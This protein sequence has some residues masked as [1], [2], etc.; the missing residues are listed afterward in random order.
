MGRRE[1]SKNI[2]GMTKG[3]GGLAKSDFCNKGKMSGGGRGF[4][5]P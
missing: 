4:G 2:L 5:S 1:S 3:E